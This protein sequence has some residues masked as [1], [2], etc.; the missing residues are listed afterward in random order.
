MS[1]NEGPIHGEEYEVTYFAGKDEVGKGELKHIEHTHVAAVSPG[2][3]VTVLGG[4][5]LVWQ[6]RTKKPFA[7]QGH[8][9]F[10]NVLVIQMDDVFVHVFGNHIIVARQY[11]KAGQI[12]HMKDAEA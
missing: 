5:S 6:N 3:L 4:N 7:E 8:R 9:V 10:E 11:F 12:P 2:H 1:D